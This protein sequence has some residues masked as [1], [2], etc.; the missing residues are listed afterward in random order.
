MID[1]KYHSNTLGASANQLYFEAD[2]NEIQKGRVFYKTD[3]AGR[4]N[5]SLLFT[6]IIDSTYS[7]GSK[8]QKNRVLPKWNIHKA[9][10]AVYPMN[11][12]ENGI[13]T[14]PC[15]RLF[16][17]ITFDGKA[18]KT[19]SEREIF[20]SDEFTLYAEKGDYICIELEF[21]GSELPCHEESL[22]PIYRHTDGE[23]R[24]DKRVPLPACIGCDKASGARIAFFGDSITQ[25]I[26]TACNSY[27]HWN[28]LL[29]EMLGDGYSYWNLGI[30]Y[31]RADDAASE[32]IWLEKALMNDVIFVCLGV[33]DLLQGFSE[34]EIKDSLVK[35]V[36]TLKKAGK[37]V[38]L[39]TLPPFDYNRATIEIWQNIN[40]FIKTESAI[41][42]D[43]VFDCVTVLGKEGSPHNARFGGHPNE[44]GCA[45]WAQEL[46]KSI[47]KSNLL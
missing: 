39:Q 46:F 4:F 24:Y 21:S 7:D 27:L 12:F 43:L 42:A 26:G 14:I 40:E 9:S 6:S 17:P 15:E 30:G 23:W 34:G 18:E 36:D 29:A 20:K 37:T 32:G 10:F 31:A 11:S 16:C 33:N 47:K 3:R 38:I 45:L 44:Q 19:V 1:Y 8:S 2:P 41:K 35:I 22:L 5:Y 13:D 25:G 28:A